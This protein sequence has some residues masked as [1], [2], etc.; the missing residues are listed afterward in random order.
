M[1]LIS[2][3]IV[4]NQLFI[5]PRSY[6][7]ATATSVVFKNEDTGKFTTI[8]P[9]SSGYVS[10]NLVL[11]IE[12]PTFKEG[13]RYTFDVKQLTTLIFKG[14]AL[15]TEYNDVNYTINNNEFIVDTD[16]DSNEMKVYE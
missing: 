14:T 10:N 5:L 1:K 12:V 11:D 7:G 15:V 13:E 8:T 16:T 2:P 6:N 4:T 9:T 3:N